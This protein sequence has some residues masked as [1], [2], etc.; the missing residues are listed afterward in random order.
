[1]DIDLC[2][3]LLLICNSTARAL[4]GTGIRLRLLSADRKSSPVPDSS[5]ASDLLQSLDIHRDVSAKI[6]LDH[7]IKLFHRRTDLVDFFIGQIPDAGIR[8]DSGLS[9]NPVR[10]GTADSKDVGQADLNSLLSW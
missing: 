10:G 4:A 6:T 2:G 7:Y 9:Q 3:L 5:V 1:M 8:V